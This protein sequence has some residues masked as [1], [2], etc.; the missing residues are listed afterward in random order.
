MAGS[1]ESSSFA[2]TGSSGRG[3]GKGNVVGQIFIEN[4]VWAAPKQLMAKKDS[5]EKGVC[6]MVGGCVCLMLGGGHA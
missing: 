6:P 5:I 2:G 3:R 4:F 1:M